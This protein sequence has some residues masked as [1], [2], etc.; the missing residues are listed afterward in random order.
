MINFGIQ[1]ASIKFHCITTPR[2]HSVLRYLSLVFNSTF[3]AIIFS[4][5]YFKWFLIVRLIFTL[6]FIVTL[7]TGV[8]PRIFIIFSGFW[9]T[10]HALTHGFLI[11]MNLSCINRLRYFYYLHFGHCLLNIHFMYQVIWYLRLIVVYKSNFRYCLFC[12]CFC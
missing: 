11:P 5:F 10:I 4:C 9:V 6:N 8:V 12:Y 1:T 7:V 2:C 3:K